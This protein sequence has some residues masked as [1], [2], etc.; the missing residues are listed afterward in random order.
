MKAS[1]R[2][3]YGQ[4]LVELGR[5]NEDI[6]VLDADLSCST[7]TQMFAREFPD[8]FFNMGIAE[9]NM[10]GVAA[11]LASA[12]KVPFANTFAIFLTGRAWEQIRQTVAYV[13][14]NVKIVAS[15]GGIT[16][17]DDG[18][19]HQA[20][21][22]IALMRILPNM[23][24]ISPADAIEMVQ[25][26]KGVSTYYGPVY[27]R[28]SR[29]NFPLV[30]KDKDYT[31]QIGKGN[32][33]RKGSD[34]TIIAAGLMVHYAL[35]AAS[36]L[37]LKGVEAEIINM[38][39]I[40]PIDE[41]LIIASAKKTGVVLTVEEHSI[42]GGLGSA[43]CEVLSLDYPVLVKR[44]GIHDRFGISGKPEQLLSYF[45]LTPQDIAIE[46]KALLKSKPRLVQTMG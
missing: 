12:G 41:E 11:G 29:L 5:I 24:V 10:I 32:I 2:E 36:F 1:L 30:Y 38:S 25:V 7:K 45:R 40:K 22:D 6:V 37:A 42:I 3:A 35:E 4:T 34:I 46:A 9:Q 44:M 26:I 16:V 43:V 28:S 13:G 31:F 39:T 27:V 33:L 19:S 21:E 18:G 8:R 15:H 14:L 20:L 23:T 17:G